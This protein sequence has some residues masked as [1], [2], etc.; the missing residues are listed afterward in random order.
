MKL[1]VVAYVSVGL[2]L[3]S[4]SGIK[5]AKNL[6]FI[7][8]ILFAVGMIANY[9]FGASWNNLLSSE[10]IQYRYG[11]IRPAGYFGHYAPNSY[12]FSLILITLFMLST[13]NLIIDKSVQVRKFY[14]LI[15]IDFLAAYPLTVRKG[16][17]MIIP[18]GLYILSLLNPTKRAV[19]TVCASVFIAGF[20]FF[21]SDSDM[22]LDTISNF[23]NFFTDDHA[24][25]RGLIVYYGFSLF[26][27]F[28]PLGVGN[29]LYGTYFSNMN[30]SV[31]EYVGLNLD[32]LTS[33]SGALLGVYDSGISA[34]IAESGFIGF[35]LAI[36]IIKE[37]FNYNKKHLDSYNYKIFKIITYFALIL[38]IT[39][40]V[41]QNGFFTTFYTSSLLYIYSKNYRYKING[42]WRKITST[43]ASPPLNQETTIAEA[44]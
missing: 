19:F 27:E 13:K 4:R 24:Y 21:I 16:L 17:F 23:N 14:L 6:Y 30:S 12:F 38:S 22:F 3:A 33:D 10:P 9:I 31:Y 8:I 41:W 1:F 15:V 42:A 7:F 28:F 37:F 39:E 18:Y 44:P 26:S 25:I 5:I 43:S 2:F 29:G 34:F 32:V 36:F 11:F 20:I 35:V 40:P